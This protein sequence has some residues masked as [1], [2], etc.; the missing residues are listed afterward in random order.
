[1]ISSINGVTFSVSFHWICGSPWALMSETPRKDCASLHP[2]NWNIS[3][4]RHFVVLSGKA[5][6]IQAIKTTWDL[7]YSWTCIKNVAAEHPRCH[8]WWGARQLHASPLPKER[9][10]TLGSSCPVQAFP[11]QTIFSKTKMSS[12]EFIESDVQHVWLQ[13][14]LIWNV[15]RCV[16][17][18]FLLSVGD[19][20]SWNRPLFRVCMFLWPRSARC[21]LQGSNFCRNPQFIKLP[22]VGYR[23]T[24]LDQQCQHQFKWI[25]SGMV[26]FF[27]MINS[28]MLF[29]LFSVL[30]QVT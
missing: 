8:S 24:A 15:R 30:I 20:L 6:K 28:K 11:S 1:M 17:G 10:P 2:W 14:L 26:S 27:R 23:D 29:L 9:S 4:T 25:L 12:N 5:R 7:R 13:S 16:F 22:I 19:L 21:P 18:S 3:S